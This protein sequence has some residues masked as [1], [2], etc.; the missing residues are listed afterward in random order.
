MDTQQ[1][2]T[3]LTKD[4]LRWATDND[5]AT[6]NWSV[7]GFSMGGGSALALTERHPEYF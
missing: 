1:W 3:F 5:L 7:G 6:S 4:L 2:E